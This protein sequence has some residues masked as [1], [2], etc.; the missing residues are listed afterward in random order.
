M[1]ATGEI[2]VQKA[3][4]RIK[5][6]LQKRHLVEKIAFGALWLNAGLVILV[7]FFVIFYSS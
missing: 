2:A 1:N 7:L 3:Q 5:A 6:S 4:D